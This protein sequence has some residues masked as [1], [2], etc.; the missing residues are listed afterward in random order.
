MRCSA[1]VTIVAVLSLPGCHRAISGRS[2]FP[3]AQSESPRTFLDS[4]V[5]PPRLWVFSGGET[6]PFCLLLRHDGTAEFYS[7]FEFLNPVRWRYDAAT[8]R[9]DLFLSHLDPM[10]YLVL[11]D[12]L[13]RGYILAVDT[14]AG[15]VS[16]DVQPRRPEIS[17]FNWVL[18]PAWRL[19]TWQ[20]PAARRNCPVLVASTN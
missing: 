15:M 6:Q 2:G 12:N 10:Q 16:H 5:T 9:L 11:R 20:L 13:T 1:A 8:H 3:V 4:T 7:G 17:V 19:R 18:V 14:V